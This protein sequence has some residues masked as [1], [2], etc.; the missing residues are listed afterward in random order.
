MAIDVQDLNLLTVQETAALLR[1]SKRSIRRK[2]AAGDL[3]AIRLGG[4]GTPLRFDSRELE[5]WLRENHAS[6]VSD[7]GSP[8]RGSFAGAAS[9]ERREASVL[10]QSMGRL[11]PI[12]NRYPTADRQ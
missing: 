8:Q 7:D 9:P 1:Q 11:D 6:P 5:L 10:G 3:P 12:V 4:P 2:V